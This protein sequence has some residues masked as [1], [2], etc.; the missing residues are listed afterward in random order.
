M[1]NQNTVLQLTII[2]IFFMH[3]PSTSRNGQVATAGWYGQAFF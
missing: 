3:F 2:L 1:T